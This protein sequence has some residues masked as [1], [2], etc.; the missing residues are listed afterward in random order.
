M[1]ERNRILYHRWEKLALY[2]EEI[3]KGWDGHFENADLKNG[4]YTWRF[5]YDY[6]RELIDENGFVISI[7]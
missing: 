6:D 5:I 3:D 7:I 4:S 2:Y 1:Y